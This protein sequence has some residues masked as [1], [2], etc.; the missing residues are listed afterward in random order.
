L[1][2]RLDAGA[3]CVDGQGGGGEPGV[4]DGFAV[5]VVARV[6][7]GDGAG[8]APAQYAAEELCGLVEAGGDHDSV[9]GGEHAAGA[10][11][12]AGER[13]AQLDLA[14]RVS[15]AEGL[16]AGAGEDAAGG[17]PAATTFA[18]RPLLVAPGV[19]STLRLP[20]EQR[21]HPADHVHLDLPPALAFQVLDDEGRLTTRYRCVMA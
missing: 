9:R 18:G 10:A 5:E 11:E 17:T 4:L 1:R 15:G 12:V 14:L 6:L 20:W 7:H 13:G 16:G 8:A 19:V 2:Q 3:V 21:A